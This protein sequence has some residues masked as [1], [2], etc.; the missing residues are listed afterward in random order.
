MKMIRKLK[1]FL[2]RKSRPKRPRRS[3]SRRTPVLDSGSKISAKPPHASAPTPKP[4]KRRKAKGRLRRAWQWYWERTRRITLLLAGLT[5]TALLL[6][7]V[8]LPSIGELNRVIKTP[9]IIIKSEDGEILGSYGDVYGEYIPFRD[10]PR[11]LLEAVIATEDRNFYRHFGIDPFGLARAMWT[12][13]RAG[14]LVQG[15]STLTQQVAKNVFLSPDRTLMRKIREMMLAFK[16]EYRFT[17]EDI[18]TIYLNRVYLG[19]GTFGVDAASRRYFDKSAR[20]LNVSESALVAGL[21]KAPSR[22]APTANVKLA[23]GRAEQVLLNMEDAGYLTAKQVEAA[24]TQLQSLMARRTASV[25]SAMYFTDWIVDQIPDL[26]G[27]AQGDLEIISTLNPK[28]QRLSEQAVTG[29]MDQRAG[30]MNAEQAALISLN[31][32]GAV[33]AMVGGRS[34]GESQYNR[35][36]QSKRQPGSAFKLFVYLTALEG[37]LSPDSM[38]DDAPIRIGKWQP[39]NYKP[40]YRGAMPLRDAL[41]QSINTVAVS[42]SERYGRRNVIAMANRLGI[43][44]EIRPDPSIALGSN[45]LT[46]LELSTA[47]AHL[48]S[49][50]LNVEPYGIVEIKSDDGRILYRH[51]SAGQSTILSKNIVGMMNE[52]L[53]HAVNAGTGASARIGR[54]IAGKTGTTSDYKDAWFIGYTPDLTTG[55]WVGNDDATPMK[56]VTGGSLPA[57]I[58]RDFMKPALAGIPAHEIPTASRD[59]S[60]QQALPWQEGQP[61]PEVQDAPANP[62]AEPQD[63]EL[64]ASFWEKLSHSGDARR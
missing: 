53:I 34:Y 16:L 50:G 10:L 55:V 28:L 5:A 6:I 26:I 40:G 57:A 54:E 21:L 11:P 17:K 51:S 63:F 33:R 22:Y 29:V 44:S 43:T 31:P 58:W 14:H 12:N 41:A 52:M 4:R 46:L 9:S 7:W 42:L 38:V 49:D 47:Y 24:K 60:A 36:T 2:K 19:A 30:A 64:G 1:R 18:L 23:R 32:D 3:T 59:W 35:V 39:K 37:G 62:N 56:K 27:D 8:T 20:D 25:R 45:E 15:G 13:F 61:P 48:C